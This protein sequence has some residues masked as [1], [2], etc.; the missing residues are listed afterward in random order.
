M[1]VC[2]CPIREAADR[3]LVCGSDQRLRNLVKRSLAACGRVTALGRYV[4]LYIATK[5]LSVVRRARS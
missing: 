1:H 5:R 4:E 3:P 2:V